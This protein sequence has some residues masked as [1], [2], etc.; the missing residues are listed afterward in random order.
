MRS[1][2]TLSHSVAVT[3]SR[4]FCICVH[5]NQGN[6]RQYATYCENNSTYTPPEQRMNAFPSDDK[7]TLLCCLPKTCFEFYVWCRMD[8]QPNL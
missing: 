1:V 5:Q 3:L 4:K 7:S 2:D 6:T 8:D